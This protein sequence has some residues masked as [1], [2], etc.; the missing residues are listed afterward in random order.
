M[1]SSSVSASCV[2]DCSMAHIIAYGV[3]RCTRTAEMINCHPSVYSPTLNPSIRS[4][5]YLKLKRD[6]NATQI[7]N[8]YNNQPKREEIRNSSCG[9]QRINQH[10]SFHL[11]HNRLIV[12]MLSLHVMILPIVWD[13]ELHWKGDTLG[14]R[15]ACTK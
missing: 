12:T 5:W 13:G 10:C 14:Y 15:T 3:V 4:D 9:C 7:K 8:R 2:S 11:K 6:F 1:A